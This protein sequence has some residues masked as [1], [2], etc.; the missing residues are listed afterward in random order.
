[1]FIKHC[2]V[3]V[4]FVVFQLAE[5]SKPDE[6]V[7]KKFSKSDTIGTIDK[8]MRKLFS[9]P[10]DAETR[11]WTKYSQSTYEQLTKMESTVQDVGIYS[12]QVI[13]IERKSEDGTW[14]RQATK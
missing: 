4:Y 10:E 3:E 8:E 7:K 14:P 11:L 9:I 12:S 6:T 13:L 5:N 1:M 2:K